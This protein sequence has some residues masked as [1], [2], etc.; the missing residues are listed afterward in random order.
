[1]LVSRR[2]ER[3]SMIVTSNTPFSGWGEVLGDDV[4]AT[5]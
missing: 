1:M 4:T 3:G 2:Y 5:R